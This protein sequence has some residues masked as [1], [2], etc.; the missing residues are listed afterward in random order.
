MLLWECLEGIEDP[1]DKSGRRYEL[2]SVL[3]LLL[4]GL[5]CGRKSLGQIV[6]WGRSLSPKAKEAM[7]FKKKVP[8]VATLSNLL[9][10]LH[11]GK[12]EEALRQYTLKGEK[13]LEPGTHVALDGKTLR[14]THQGDV[15]LVHLLSVFLTRTQGI[16]GQL[17]M[18]EGE[19][20]ITGALRLLSSLPLE[21]AIITGDA[22]FAQK[23]SVRS[24]HKARETISSH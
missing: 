17:R 12:F 20:E 7:G 16:L 18:E 6:L 23:K 24:L 5:L 15:P 8:C 14:G 22:I 13:V 2:G 21:G 1:R 10:R 3:K 9:R 4:A 11:V 19:N